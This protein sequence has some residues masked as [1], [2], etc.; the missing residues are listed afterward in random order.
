MHANRKAIVAIN[1]AC[2]TDKMPIG[3][4]SISSSLAD[5]CVLVARLRVYASTSAAG[6]YRSPFG[7]MA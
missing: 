7:K 5:S 1:A 3:R 6:R 2:K 4:C